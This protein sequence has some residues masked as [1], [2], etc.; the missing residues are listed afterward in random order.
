MKHNLFV[1]ENSTIYFLF[2]NRE[3]ESPEKNVKITQNASKNPSVVN[4]P[5]STPPPLLTPTIITN[6]TQKSNNLPTTHKK[7]PPQ[8]Q[9]KS[10]EKAASNA[11]HKFIVVQKSK[12]PLKY[13]NPRQKVLN[14]TI[15]QN[16]DKNSQNKEEPAKAVTILNKSL[17]KASNDDDKA[18]HLEIK[19]EPKDKENLQYLMIK[20]EPIDWT[21][22][23]M[24]IIESKE[25]YEDMIIKSENVETNES[26]SNGEEEDEEEEDEEEEEEE[27][28]FSPLTCELCT[29]RFT[30]PAEW[31]RHV[32]TH[33]DMLP[34]KRRRR[35]SS[36][37]SY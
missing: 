10:Q 24:E 17:N 30:I 6:Q 37:V 19:T 26:E 28:M 32:Q 1:F 35:D 15:M 16:L 36:G 5:V 11:G 21:D 12:E 25:V 4:S 20:D 18:E 34:A 22:A 33:T 23:D 8:T 3:R 27:S 2:V 13:T 9:P 14:F 7:T 31:V 29:E